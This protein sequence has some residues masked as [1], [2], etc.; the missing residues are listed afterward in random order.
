[1]WPTVSG[2]T[3]LVAFQQSTWL[4]LPTG[5]NRLCTTSYVVLEWSS[6]QELILELGESIARQLLEQGTV[7]ACSPL[8]G[9]TGLTVVTTLSTL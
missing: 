2:E 7:K 6:P 8:T 4:T 1:M 5:A 3:I 9:I